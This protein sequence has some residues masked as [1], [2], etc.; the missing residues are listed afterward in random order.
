MDSI[1][2]ITLSVFALGTVIGIFL[3]KNPGFGRYTSSLLLLMVV[4]YLAAF[5]LLLGKVDQTVFINMAFAI[6]G[7]AGGLIQGKKDTQQ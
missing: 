5:F 3:T 1:P 6:A 2:I 4:L 7:Y